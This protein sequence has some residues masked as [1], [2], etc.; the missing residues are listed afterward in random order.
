M[1]R[2]LLAL[3]L[4]LSS[5]VGATTVT[6]TVTDAESQTWNNGT[7]SI[8]LVSPPGTTSGPPFFL[9]GTVTPVPNQLQVGTLSGTGTASLTLTDNAT[10]AP[11]L[12]VWRFTIC[13]QATAPCFV[14]A[15]QIVGASQTVNLVPPI[16]RIPGANIPPTT[17]A[18]TDAEVANPGLGTIYYNLVSGVSRQWNGVVWGPLAGGAASGL[19]VTATGTIA[20]TPQSGSPCPPGQGVW[21]YGLMG[22]ANYK[23]LGSWDSTTVSPPLSP[24]GTLQH[25]W[26][27]YW[28]TT[29]AAM[30][31]EKN[32][33]LGML[34]VPSDGSDG[35]G[36]GIISSTSNDQ[37]VIGITINNTGTGQNFRQ[38]QDIYADMALSG[39]PTFGGIAGG[40]NNAGVFRGNLSDNR[41]QTPVSGSRFFVY[42]AQYQRLGALSYNSCGAGNCAGGYISEVDNET[43][44]NAGGTVLNAFAAY[45][46]NNAAATNLSYVAFESTAPSPRFPS[47]NYGFWSR[48]MGTNSAD[49]DFAGDGVNSAGTASGFNYFTGPVNF[50]NGNAVKAAAG[51]QVDV[52]GALKL[53]AGAG[54]QNVDY[55]GSTSGDA[56]FAAAAVAGTPNQINWPT[57]TAPA[58]GALWASDGGNPQ[59]TYWTWNC[60]N[61]TPVTVSANVTT[62][63]TLMSCTIP[64]GT[65][66]NVG[67]NLHL[68]SAFVYSTPAASVAAVTMK[69]KLCTVS[70]C[71]S[72]TVITPCAFTSSAN[73]GTVTNNSIN[74]LCDATTQTAG[75]TASFESHGNMTIDLGASPGLADSVFSDTNTA[76]VGTIDSTVQ[77]FA[78]VTGAFSVASA[79]NSLTQR[80]MLADSQH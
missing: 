15:V 19:T 13:P 80:Q 49:F 59:Q 7:Y 46:A 57:I 40:E 4:L 78:Q 61:L 74:F 41:A 38:L 44:G 6:L 42:A 72:G 26:R 8:Q 39:T 51:Y 36:G 12:S 29:G 62:D 63:Q 70:G 54:V 32:R 68:W 45:S 77:L 64:A 75:A 50:G 58:V 2:L 9:N 48:D 25:C 73:P 28:N 18:Y 21:I 16:I 24:T 30:A 3:F 22:D 66:N 60:S 56:K 79:S 33:L 27:E 55:F 35:L 65:L 69:L 20:P 76:T 14:Q 37:S 5:L 17:L 23:A 71:G 53:K 34:H 1:R 67:R 10:I 43:T 52:L 11:A 31:G 47:A